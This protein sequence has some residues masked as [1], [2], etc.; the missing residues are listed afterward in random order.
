MNKTISL[1]VILTFSVGIVFARERDN[2]ETGK[3]FF[4]T[5]AFLY[6]YEEIGPD[7]KFNTAGINWAIGLGYDFGP[8]EVNLLIDSMLME[9]VMYQGYGYSAYV[10]I[11]DAHN[12]GLG[13]NAGIKLLNGRIFDI[14]LPAGV[15]AHSSRFEIEH[16]NERKFQYTYIN[17]ETGLMLSWR[18][19]K[20]HAI[21]VPFNIG[22]PVYKDSKAENYTKKDYEVFHYSAG[23]GIRS[24][25]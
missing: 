21:Y 24:M 11:K 3:S 25:F 8:V 20:Y 12:S 2:E 18:L 15:L 10:Q 4:I 13:L 23:L 22:Y 19:S 9:E 7:P 14:I 17:I 5:S 1:A 6:N 16:D